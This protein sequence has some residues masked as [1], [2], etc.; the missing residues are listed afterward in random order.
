MGWS[1]RTKVG[2]GAGVLAA[3]VIAAAC[4]VWM[5]NT[6]YR[7]GAANG[8]ARGYVAGQEAAKDDFVRMACQLPGEVDTSCAGLGLPVCEFEDGTPEGCLWVQD[9]K[10]WWTVNS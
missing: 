2:I 8:Y 1:S 10:A 4:A 6:Q 9:G 3:V 7:H 5:A